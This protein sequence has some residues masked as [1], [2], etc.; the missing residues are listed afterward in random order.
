MTISTRATII[1]GSVVNKKESDN[2]K[3][4]NI[5]DNEPSEHTVV[6]EKASYRVSKM[7]HRLRCL[8]FSNKVII[9]SRIAYLQGGQS[10]PPKPSCR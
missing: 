3:E 2:G 6:A 8:S 7:C 4:H 9:A 5:D 10:E 1:S